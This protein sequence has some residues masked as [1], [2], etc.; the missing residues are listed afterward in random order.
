MSKAAELTINDC[1]EALTSRFLVSKA[2]E[3]VVSF[4][5]AASAWSRS[6]LVSSF[7]IRAFS[8]V[9]SKFFAAS[10]VSKILS[11]AC[12]FFTAKL[13][14]SSSIWIASFDFCNI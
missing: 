4:F 13:D 1:S 9:Y 14:F 8:L 11:T 7:A 12:A 2:D 10:S 6:S 3:T 5:A